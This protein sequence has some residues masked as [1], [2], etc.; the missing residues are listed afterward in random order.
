MKIQVN[1]KHP[2]F[3]SLSTLSKDILRVT[4]RKSS[5]F[6]N[7]VRNQVLEQTLLNASI[8]RQLTPE[9]DEYFQKFD[10]TVD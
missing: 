5:F 9:Q 7:A 4:F 8:D 10:E 6:M 2:N 3:I 1:F